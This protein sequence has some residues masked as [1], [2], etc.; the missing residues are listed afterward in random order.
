MWEQLHGMSLAEGCAEKNSS[1]CL[2]LYSRDR[3]VLRA[4]SRSLVVGG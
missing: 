4:A 2:W 1:H 3:N